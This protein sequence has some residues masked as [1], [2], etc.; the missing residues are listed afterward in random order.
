MNKILSNIK[1]ITLI[2]SSISKCINKLD[3]SIK[4][5]KKYK[6]A[7]SNL[8]RNINLKNKSHKNNNILPM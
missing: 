3:K 8:S 1:K 5:I 7:I 2:P 4:I 6:R